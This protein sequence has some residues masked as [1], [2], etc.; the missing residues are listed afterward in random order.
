MDKV[1]TLF[2][3]ADIGTEAL[4]ESRLDRLMLQMPLF[5]RRGL[6]GNRLAVAALVYLGLVH[7]GRAAGDAA[8]GA[9]TDGATG[10]G[11]V[12]SSTEVIVAG[13]AASSIT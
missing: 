1:D 11:M 4:E 8:L 13:V 12:Q 5:R 7:G 6:T 10:A 9:A 3:W 2:N